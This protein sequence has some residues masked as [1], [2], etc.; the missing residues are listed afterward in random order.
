[1]SMQKPAACRCNQ[2]FLRISSS[3]ATFCWS[4]YKVPKH[5]HQSK[6]IGPDLSHCLTAAFCTASAIGQTF[7]IRQKE[8]EVYLGKSKKSPVPKNGQNLKNLYPAIIAPL[9]NQGNI[10]KGKKL[11]SIKPDNRFISIFIK[12]FMPHKTPDFIINYKNRQISYF[13]KLYNLL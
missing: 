5:A 9:E 12:Y 13:I 1:M 10:Y 11:L 6:R 4:A 8:R 2:L 7:Q 3:L